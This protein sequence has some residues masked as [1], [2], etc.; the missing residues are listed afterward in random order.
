MDGRFYPLQSSQYIQ[1]VSPSHYDQHSA[2]FE[3]RLSSPHSS[4]SDTSEDGSLNSN[5]TLKPPSFKHKIDI[6]EFSY[7]NSAFNDTNVTSRG[8]H[9]DISDCSSVL[10]TIHS[11]PASLHRQNSLPQAY[12][13]EYQQK[14][15]TYVKSTDFIHTKRQMTHHSSER[16]HSS[17]GQLQSAD[18]MFT[19][20]QYSQPAPQPP[21]PPPAPQAPAAPPAPPAPPPAPPAAPGAPPAPPPPPGPGAPPPPAPPPVPSGGP[22]PSKTGGG[23]MG[24]LAEALAK[25][26]NALKHVE[27]N[28]SINRNLICRVT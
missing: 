14:S 27:T 1:L 5:E 15:P 25:K 7:H 22:S 23:G 2:E 20:S 13:T 26:S 11:N 17:P 12:A 18:Y 3:A 19:G 6:R 8:G 16:K 28:V 9:S 4:H 10:E 24:S 21:G